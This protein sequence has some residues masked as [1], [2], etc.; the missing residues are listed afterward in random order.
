[1]IHFCNQL[2]ERTVSL[3]YLYKCQSSAE[4]IVLRTIAHLMKTN[5]R[6]TYRRLCSS[7]ATSQY[8]DG[9]RSHKK[10]LRE[11]GVKIMR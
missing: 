7:G 1:M 10:P 11:I 6:T 5:W 8:V 3:Q 4:D 9:K 2:F